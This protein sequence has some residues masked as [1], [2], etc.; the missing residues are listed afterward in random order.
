MPQILKET[1]EEVR[2]CPRE[3]IFTRSFQHVDVPTL[4]ISKEHPEMERL[5]SCE[6]V[7]AINFQPVDVPVAKQHVPDDTC[8]APAPVIKRVTFAPDDMPVS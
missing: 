5:S 2:L 1:V 8:A 7:S 4:Q 6:H 3:H